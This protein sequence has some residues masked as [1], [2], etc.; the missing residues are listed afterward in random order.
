[1][2]KMK[3][4]HILIFAVFFTLFFGTLAVG[5]DLQNGFMGYKWG[6]DISQYKALTM[7][8]AKGDV[9]YYSHP[10]ELYTI[11]D[12]QIDT[13]VFGFYKG[14]FFAVY[15]AIGGL[16]TYDSV[17]MYMKSKYGLPSTKL[18]SKDHLTTNKW[19]YKDVVI[20]LKTDEIGGKMKLAIYYKPISRDLRNDQLEMV[21][22]ASFQFFPIDKNEKPKML[23][24]LKF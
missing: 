3:K 23:P 16:D 9:T 12:I 21:D 18:S 11:D 5:A 17:M 7:L 14:D 8:H 4:F 20:K 15:A 2:K 19:K 22:E 10:D 6:E 13:I 24:F 1:M